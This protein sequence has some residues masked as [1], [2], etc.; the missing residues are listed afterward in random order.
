M[1]KEH[2]SYNSVKKLCIKLQDLLKSN[3]DS[4]VYFMTRMIFKSQSLKNL[5]ITL[6]SLTT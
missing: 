6:L 4:K 5:R 3:L 2:T 1:T